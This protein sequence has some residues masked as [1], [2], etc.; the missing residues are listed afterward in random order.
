MESIVPFKKKKTIMESI[1][2]L[3]KKKNSYV[4]YIAMAMD[5]M[6]KPTMGSSARQRPF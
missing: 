1:V 6:K 4:T 5:L 2:P 3:L